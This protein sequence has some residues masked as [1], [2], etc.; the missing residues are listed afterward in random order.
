MMQLNT[1][2]L[3]AP[4]GPMMLWMRCLLDLEVEPVDG[5]QAAEALG[6]LLGL[7]EDAWPSCLRALALQI[8]GRPAAVSAS[9]RISRRLAA[10]GHR[11]SGF[12][13]MTAMIARP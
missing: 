5:D 6:H 8:G 4:L 13:R 11:P 3:P 9:T 12:S 10:D 7:E 2:V 1:V